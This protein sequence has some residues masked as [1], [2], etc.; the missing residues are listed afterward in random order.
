[1]YLQPIHST[2]LV[3]LGI[4]V[5]NHCMG[6]GSR[7][8]NCIDRSIDIVLKLE[9]FHYYL[10]YHFSYSVKFSKHLPWDWTFF[11]VK[12]HYWQKPSNCYWF[13]V[14]NLKIRKQIYINC[15]INKS[16]YWNTRFLI[17]CIFTRNLKLKKKKTN[18][19]FFCTSFKFNFNKIW[20]LNEK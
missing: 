20:C 2:H 18:A 16:I 19:L 3:W 6:V 9:T 15:Y 7:A 13:V 5:E 10:N 4:P 12:F 14:K 17:L 8:S 11:F 1:M